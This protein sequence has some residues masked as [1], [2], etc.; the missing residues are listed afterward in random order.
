MF[1]MSALWQK[2]PSLV[3][4][5]LTFLICHLEPAADSRR[6]A[7]ADYADEIG[8]VPPSSVVSHLRLSA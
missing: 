3:I 6:D 5:H 2:P 1:R 8:E 7:A 4:C